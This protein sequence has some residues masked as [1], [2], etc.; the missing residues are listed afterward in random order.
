MYSY[1]FS[2][3]PQGL[4]N[5]SVQSIR[6]KDMVKQIGFMKEIQAYDEFA[7]YYKIILK[8]KLEDDEEA[9]E[10]VS[11]FYISRMICILTFTN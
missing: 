1:L 2:I 3:S 10:A 8:Q 7:E 9:V 6:K 4:L 5:S 11:S